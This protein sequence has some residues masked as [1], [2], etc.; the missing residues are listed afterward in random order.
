MVAPQVKTALTHVGTAFGGAVAAVAFL[1]QHQIDLYAAWNQLNEVV[2][3]VSKF[4]ALLTPI[5]TGAY[6]V[7]RTSTKVRMAEI[8]QD[9]KAVEA[10]E[11]L[12]VTPNSAAV[13]AALVKA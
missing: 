9:P 2:A 6:G 5:V 7:Y 11:Q 10:A 8:V 12:P 4:V 13:A 1:S 3:A